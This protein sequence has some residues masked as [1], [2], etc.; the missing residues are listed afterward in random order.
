M[1]DASQ[2][3]YVPKGAFFSRAGNLGPRI[4]QKPHA[5]LHT[6]GMWGGHHGVTGLSLRGVVWQSSV[7]VSQCLQT[8][9]QMRKHLVSAAGAGV[10]READGEVLMAEARE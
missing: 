1:L 10:W 5:E 4:T 2:P 7:P 8:N 3:N 9:P 6:A